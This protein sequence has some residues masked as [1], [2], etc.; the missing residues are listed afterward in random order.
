MI[1]CQRQLLVNILREMWSRKGLTPSGLVEVN[2]S[3][4]DRLL[5]ERETKVYQSVWRPGNC[6]SFYQRGSTDKR[7]WSM[8]IVARNNH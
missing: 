2:S 5:R 7:P 1:E 8:A 4:T 6:D 3:P